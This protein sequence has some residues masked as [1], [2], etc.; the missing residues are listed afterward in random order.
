ML[1]QRM[2]MISIFAGIGAV[3]YALYDMGVIF[4]EMK[5]SL[6]EW[7]QLLCIFVN[8]LVM[9][10]LGSLISVPLAFLPIREN[11]QN[12]VGFLNGYIS[13]QAIAGFFS[14]STVSYAL[15]SLFICVLC[16]IG[17]VV[18]SLYKD[19]DDKVK[20]GSVLFVC[21][22]SIGSMAGNVPKKVKYETVRPN[23]PNV[24]LIGI[25]ALR[26]DHLAENGHPFINT[27][28]FSRLSAEGV[29]LENAFAQVG[30]VGGDYGHEFEY[31]ATWD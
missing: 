28:G 10:G 19:A 30:M 24:L 8:V 26:F 16:A 23:T 2:L 11:N 14:F 15:I 29:F 25:D 1:F 27:D 31:F 20:M 12:W 13:A 6:N 5:F 7:Q 4:F 9:G 17:I 3:L 18:F 22:A 21:F